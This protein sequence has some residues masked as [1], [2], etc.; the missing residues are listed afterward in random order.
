PSSSASADPLTNPNGIDPRDDEQ[1]GPTV[2]TTNP[3]PSLTAV[4]GILLVLSIPGVVR[5]V[6]R[7]QLLSA[8]RDGDTA[9]VWTTVQDAAIDIGIPVP[10]S[11]SP[12]SFASRL[13]SDHDAPPEAMEVLVS[14]I[15]RASYAP[16]RVRDYWHGDEVTDAADA[17]R[18]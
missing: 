17:A 10:A 18:R 7:R 15:E 4:L 11:E 6:R 9:A 13:I 1:S 14:A 2:G 12:R 16:A 3:L 5:H 8:A